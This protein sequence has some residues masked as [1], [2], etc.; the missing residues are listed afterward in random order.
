M[1]KMLKSFDLVNFAYTVVSVTTRYMEYPCHGW[2]RMS[3]KPRLP[4][5]FYDTYDFLPQM[6]MTSNA[7]ELTQHLALFCF[8]RISIVFLCCVCFL[9]S[10]PFFFFAFVVLV[11][12]SS[13]H[14]FYALW[15]F[16]NFLYTKLHMYTRANINKNMYNKNWNKQTLLSYAYENANFFRFWGSWYCKHIYKVLVSVLGIR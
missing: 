11:I 2:Q 10:C 3:D 7:V 14:D 13:I 1:N 4:L 9:L 5:F 15:V 6:T 16:R 8:I 12:K